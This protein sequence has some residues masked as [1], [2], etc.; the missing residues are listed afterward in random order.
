M[1]PAQLKQVIKALFQ[2]K[3]KRPILLWGPPGCGKSQVCQQVAAELKVQY[4]DIRLPYCEPGDIKFPVVVDGRLNWVNSLFPEDRPG[5]PPFVGIVNL[6][7]LAQS[8]TI[9]QACT[10]QATLD[11]MVGDSVISPGA[12]FIA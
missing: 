3:E 10:M 1:R 8:T 5:K 9:V 4:K 7:E 2:S 12:Y 6:E 11:R